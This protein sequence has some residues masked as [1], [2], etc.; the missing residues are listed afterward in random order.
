MLFIYLETTLKYY[1]FLNSIYKSKAMFCLE[2]LIIHDTFVR[3]ISGYSHMYVHK[4][5][6]YYFAWLKHTYCTIN[7][8][9]NF[10]LYLFSYST[11]IMQSFR[12]IIRIFHDNYFMHVSHSMLVYKLS[13]NIS[14]IFYA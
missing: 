8:Q 7:L 5:T 10:H 1:A 6:M 2:I 11:V 4:M 13:F 9:Y 3:F 12:I 14:C